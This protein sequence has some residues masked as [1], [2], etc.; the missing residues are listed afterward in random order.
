MPFIHVV[1]AEL[2]SAILCFCNT[3]LVG[4]I[5]KIFKLPEDRISFFSPAKPGSFGTPLMPL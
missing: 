3:K 2:I 4:M 5:F 1:E